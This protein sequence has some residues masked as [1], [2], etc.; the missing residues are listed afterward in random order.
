MFAP[1]LKKRLGEALSDG[2]PFAVIR[3]PGESPRLI[4]GFPDSSELIIT[5]WPGSSPDCSCI[6]PETP[7]STYLENLEKL[8]GRLKKRGLSK[9]VFSRIITPESSSTDWI[10]VAERLWEEFPDC[11]GYF[12][13]TPTLGAWLGASPELLLEADAAGRFS[14]VALAGTLRA[15]AEWDEKNIVEQHIVADYIGRVLTDSGASFESDGPHSQLFGKIKHLVTRFTG[16]LSDPHSYTALLERLAPT[17]AL[18]GFP[19]EEAINDIAQ[20][21]THSRGCY[22][23]YITVKGA[24]TVSFVV[25]R[26]VHFNPATSEAAVY[27][28]GGITSDSVPAIEEEETRSKAEALCRIIKSN[29]IAPARL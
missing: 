21:E 14:T 28:G 24:R 4:E 3:L 1:D 5:G 23:G 9:T 29:Q 7:R 22:G 26:C 20:L 2:S 25:I 15:D 13:F 12:F 6:P 27:V 18:A 19:K 8:I 16:T 17:P 11:F 10:G